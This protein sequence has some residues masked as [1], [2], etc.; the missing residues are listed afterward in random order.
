MAVPA[1]KN[2]RYR[3]AKISEY[4]LRR[5]VECFAANMTVKDAVA[6]TKLSAPSVDAIFMRLRERMRDYGLFRLEPNPGEPHP[7][8]HIFNRKH[9]GVPEH[10]QD[11]Y[12]IE[13]IHRVLCAQNLRG[14]EELSASNAAHVRRAIQLHGAKQEG[15][16]RY[17]VFEKLALKPGQAEPEI[18]PFAPFDYE[19]TSTLLI[20]E[21]M[22]SPETAFFRY[23]WQLL[24]RH[25]L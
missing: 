23:L 13:T 22:L 14:F 18:R 25:P 20:N 21:R 10:S 5:V 12:A 16:R 8:R 11:L 6:A 7:A 24:L 9:R 1:Q 4:R 19:T 17:T 2:R 3:N 15:K